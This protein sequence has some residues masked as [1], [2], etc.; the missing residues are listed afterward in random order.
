MERVNLFDVE[1][2]RDEGDPAGYNTDY[3]RLAP[4]LGA[5]KIGGTV[6]D[7]PRGPVGLPRTTTSTATRSG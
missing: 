3:V 1:V 4:K 5:S 6:Y 7:L 2:G